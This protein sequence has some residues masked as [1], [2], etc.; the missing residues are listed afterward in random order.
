MVIVHLFFYE[1]PALVEALPYNEFAIYGLLLLYPILIFGFVFLFANNIFA[2]FE[3]IYHRIK[4][5]KKRTQFLIGIPILTFLVFLISHLYTHK[6]YFNASFRLRG[7]P[8][9]SFLKPTSANF[10]KQNLDLKEVERNKEARKPFLNY[11]ADFNNKNDN[12]QL[13]IISDRSVVVVERINLLLKNALQGI[14]LVLIFLALFLKP[15]LAFW[16]AFGLP[17][18]FLGM[19]IFAGFFNVTINV[20][21]LFGMIIVIGILVDDGIVISPYPWRCLQLQS[22]KVHPD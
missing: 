22:R 8:I 14:I 15:R 5:L 9:Y 3:S 17:F 12:L 20:V 18:A 13:A 7:E 2:F 1:I 10:G 16:V 19:F 6:S 21:S 11:D 4:A